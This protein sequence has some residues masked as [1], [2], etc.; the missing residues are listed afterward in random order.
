MSGERFADAF[1]IKPVHTGPNSQDSSSKSQVPR[2]KWVNPK[3][4]VLGLLSSQQSISAYVSICTASLASSTNLRSLLRIENIQLKIWAI[5]YGNYLVHKNLGFP[6][7]AISLII[8][9]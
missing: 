2:R 3:V 5:Q 4:F 1:T 6:G 8:T 7:E 9:Q